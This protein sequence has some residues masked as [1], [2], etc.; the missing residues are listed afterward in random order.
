MCLSLQVIPMSSTKWDTSIARGN[1]SHSTHRQSVTHDSVTSP[2]MLSRLQPIPARCLWITAT[3]KA[4]G[5]LS[6]EKALAL[7]QRHFLVGFIQCV[8]GGLISSWYNRHGWLSVEIIYLSVSVCLSICLSIYLSIH[9]Y[10]ALSVFLFVLSPS[11]FSK[12]L[13]WKLKTN[14]KTFG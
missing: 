8:C 5:I 11:A 3:C 10:V 9:I 4:R 2:V 7:L 13:P 12:I 1:V 14:F 6:F